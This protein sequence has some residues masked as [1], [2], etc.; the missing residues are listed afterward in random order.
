MLKTTLLLIPL[1]YGAINV[2][3]T[4]LTVD[5]SYGSANIEYAQ[6]YNEYA[7]QSEP[8]DYYYKTTNNTPRND[9]LDIHTNNYSS[10]TYYEGN[11]TLDNFYIAQITPYYD[12]D[13]TDIDLTLRIRFNFNDTTGQTI[14]YSAIITD[15]STCIDYINRND[16]N[17]NGSLIGDQYWTSLQENL[18]FF[19]WIY[20]DEQSN[21]NSNTNPYLEIPIENQAINK[22]TTTY[23]VVYAYTYFSAINIGYNESRQ[24]KFMSVENLNLTATILN[25]GRAIE[26]VNI[27]GLMFDVLTL[28]FAF[29]SQAFNLTLFPGTPYQ[30]NISNI[31]LAL[32]GI[33]LLLW[34]LKIILGKAELGGMINDVQSAR[35]D[36]KVIKAQTKEA[37]YKEARSKLHEGRRGPYDI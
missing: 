31:F 3:G 2:N 27:P 17:A 13:D 7:A 11:I 15:D 29:I 34:V 20:N 35:N 6:S 23:V 19:T 24:N 33:S 16:F 4:T 8:Y 22:D 36:S 25:Y 28:P 30:V 37:Q 5:L 32:I 1:A 26:I 18:R 21:Y 9:H 12:I 10:N 14:R